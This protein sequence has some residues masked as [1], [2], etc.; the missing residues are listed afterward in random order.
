MERRLVW[1][2]A[3]LL[4][5]PCPDPSCLPPPPADPLVDLPYTSSPFL[6]CW[7]RTPPQTPTQ[8]PTPFELDLVSLPPLLWTVWLVDSPAPFWH[9]PLWFC[10]PTPQADWRQE[11]G[12]PAFIWGG[13]EQEHLDPFPALWLVVGGFGIEPS[14]FPDSQ[15][16][17]LLPS[18]CPSQ[19]FICTL[20]PA[21][22]G[23]PDLTPPHRPSSPTPTPPL[24]TPAVGYPQLLLP[25]LPPSLV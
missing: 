1:F 7:L 9:Y 12:S 21:Q 10:A 25:T 20:P 23:T 13:F 18:A 6:C 5:L 16:P 8:T 24:L 22:P 15:V 17:H 14:W 2:C 4:C 11:L 19:D 3:P